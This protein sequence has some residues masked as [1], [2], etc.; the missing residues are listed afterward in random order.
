MRIKNYI[1]WVTCKGCGNVISDQSIKCPHCG[2]WLQLADIL[3]IVIGIIAFLVIIFLL[4][5]FLDW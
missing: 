3:K 1:D 4:A 5:F 2:K